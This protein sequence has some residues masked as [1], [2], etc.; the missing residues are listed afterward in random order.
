MS[1][2]RAVAVPVLALVAAGGL[3]AGCHGRPRELQTEAAKPAASAAAVPAK[4]GKLVEVDL[5]GGISES[6][7]GGGLFGVPASRTF[8]G[9]VRA[10]DR[11]GED[12]EV[13]GVFVRLGEGGFG[14]AQTE[15]IGRMLE[16]LKR[17]KLV[18][19]HAHSLNN[20]TAWVAARGC[21]K[22]WLSPAGDVDTVGIAGQVVYLK[23]A[24]DK[25]EVDADFL[26]MGRYK[27]AVETLTRDGPSDE[28]K[29]SMLGV[30]GSIR[31][32]WLDGIA[33]SRKAPGVREAAEHGPFE[34]KE[35]RQRGLIDAIGYE[36]EALADLR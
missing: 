22:I 7:D 20:R 35:A 2:R 8:V 32:S 33:A 28:A 24:L 9:F 30:L 14:W 21:E 12:E 15:E 31:S 6:M 13:T 18:V 10:V 11:A 16:K 5:G 34:P 27:A 23:G 19:C 4:D 29:E 1:G 3:F 36:S 26:H 25:L 17:K